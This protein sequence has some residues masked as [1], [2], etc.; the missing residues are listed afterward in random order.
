MPLRA[1]CRMASPPRMLSS[2]TRQRP[3]SRTHATRPCSTSSRCPSNC[4]ACA[5]RAASSLARSTFASSCITTAALSSSAWLPAGKIPRSRT[6][7]FMGPTRFSRSIARRVS[8]GIPYCESGVTSQT[9]YSTGTS[10]HHICRGSATVWVMRFSKDAAPFP[11][12][13]SP[14]PM[15]CLS[16]GCPHTRPPVRACLATGP[17]L[18]EDHLKV[19]AAHAQLRAAAERGLPRKPAPRP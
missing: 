12:I 14:I 17:A 4:T 10:I 15:G 8:S 18:S 7:R 2:R 11:A 6:T 1:A 5:M 16:R 19:G 3:R 9:V 13:R